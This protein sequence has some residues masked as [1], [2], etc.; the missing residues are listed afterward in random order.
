MIA[1]FAQTFVKYDKYFQTL[2]RMTYQLSILQYY[3]IQD[4]DYNLSRM[5][6]ALL[7]L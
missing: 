6:E 7:Q 5:T 2:C 4:C 1:R 3:E